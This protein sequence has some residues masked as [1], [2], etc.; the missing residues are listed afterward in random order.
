MRVLLV[1]A[2]LIGHVFPL[3]P[4]GRALVAAGHEVCVATGADGMAVTKAGLAAVDTAPDFSMGRLALPIA[5]RHPLI[6]RAELRGRAGTRGVALLFAAVNDRI[7]D[8][9]VA[10]AE[11]FR[12][13]LVVYE[14]LAVAGALAAAKL[15]VPA[16]LHENML[17]DGPTLVR[18]TSSR[19][20]KALRRHGIAALPADAAT[21]SI[22]PPSVLPDRPGRP[23]RPEP[24]ATGDLDLP[25][26]ATAGLSPREAT[27]RPRVVV[28]RST[29]GASGGGLMPLVAR[30]A[31]EIDAEFVFLNPDK[32]TRIPANGR[33][34]AWAPMP[35][36][37]ETSAAVIHHGG[38]GTAIAA[39]C[40][41]VPQLV[42][43]GTGDRRH[44]ASLIAARGAGL[45]VDE[46][47]ISADLIRRVLSDPAL[48][49]AAHEVR[50]E[51]EAMPPPAALVPS[52][53][54][55]V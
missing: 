45:A 46:P 34:V 6:A 43:N 39:L 24:Y 32:K 5:L 21:I 55:L 31:A 15:G 29:V 7:A 17:F 22:A 23:M 16:V 12:P 20:G 38:A 4:L 1:S 51:V 18:V 52:L 44:N 40:A 9:V 2:P 19:L 8:A 37:L 33:A 47:E 28:T 13:D 26:P 49:A 53:E 35:A 27:A 11:E 25:A 10:A 54:A 14:P 41:G 36:L 50:A 42:V 30:V 3:V 48:R